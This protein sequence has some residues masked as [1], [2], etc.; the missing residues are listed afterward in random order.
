MNSTAK[1][2]LKQTELPVVPNGTASRRLPLRILFV[3]RDAAEVELCM[4]ELK[5]AHFRVTADVVLTPEQFAGR[6]K[7]K[8]YDVV[9]VE[10]PSPDWQGRD[11]LEMLRMQKG[12]S[13]A[14]S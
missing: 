5:S 13:P 6:V 7:A 3:H 11:E 14:F 9:L 1:D 4:Q 8:Y 2:R 12:R 10:Y